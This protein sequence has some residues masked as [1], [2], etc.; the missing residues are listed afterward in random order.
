M[1]KV[2]AILLCLLFACTAFACLVAAESEAPTKDPYETDIPQVITNIA[3]GNSADHQ[4][5]LHTG[6]KFMRI[7]TEN[8]TR[9]VKDLAKAFDDF[10]DRVHSFTVENVFSIFQ[11]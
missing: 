4:E 10:I 6:L 5:D 1:K 11:R 3:G 2:L 7:V 8:L 9:F